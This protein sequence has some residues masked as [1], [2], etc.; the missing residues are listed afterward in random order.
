MA[1]IQINEDNMIKKHNELSKWHLLGLKKWSSEFGLIKKLNENDSGRGDY[2]TRDKG[3]K[4]LWDLILYLDD[5]DLEI[6]TNYY[7]LPKYL[8]LFIKFVF[9]EVAASENWCKKNPKKQQMDYFPYK[10]LYEEIFIPKV[11]KK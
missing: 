3:N 9:N 4:S 8:Y 5:D 11:L 10:Y 1:A 2:Y 6:V 7:D